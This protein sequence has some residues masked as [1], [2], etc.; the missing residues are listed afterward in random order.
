MNNTRADK[1]NKVRGKFARLARGESARVTVHS[2]D[3]D[4]VHEVRK[5]GDGKITWKKNKPSRKER[6]A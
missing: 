3:G 1:L 2:P 5:T 4:V 6:A